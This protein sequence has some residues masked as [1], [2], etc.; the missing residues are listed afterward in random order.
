MTGRSWWAI[1]LVF[2]SSFA[3]V[4]GLIY[5]AIRFTKQQTRTVSKGP[6]MPPTNIIPPPISWDYDTYVSTLPQSGVIKDN[7]IPNV[8]SVFMK[9][10]TRTT[11]VTRTY[12][13]VT[14]QE[15][16]ATQHKHRGIYSMSSLK[17]KWGVV[18]ANISAGQIRLKD[19]IGQQ[20]GP[21][22]TFALSMWDWTNPKPTSGVVNRHAGGLDPVDW[23]SFDNSC[24]LVI[25]SRGVT[26]GL[27]V[28]YEQMHAIRATL[29]NPIVLVLNSSLA[30]DV[31]N[32]LLFS[33]S[34]DG[35]C[36]LIHSTC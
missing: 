28:R 17:L 18:T 14:M 20:S 21:R 13:P 36:F 9:G 19:N 6:Y 29:D 26:S 30:V 16:A 7:V 23:S 15:H 25:L 31:I 22:G 5:L 3:A 10:G 11:S 27:L 4:S 1:V 32:Q 12:P 33:Q 34:D 2:M 35:L 8:L 24:K